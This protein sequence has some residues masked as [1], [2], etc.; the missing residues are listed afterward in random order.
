MGE[1]W[2]TL[3]G[4]SIREFCDTEMPVYMFNKEGSFMVLTLGEVRIP[5]SL[6][7]FPVP[8]SLCSY[9]HPRAPFSCYRVF[10]LPLPSVG[11]RFAE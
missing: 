7:S 8:L 2:L 4:F 10:T 9:T 5:L 1:D 6:S 3:G 11:W